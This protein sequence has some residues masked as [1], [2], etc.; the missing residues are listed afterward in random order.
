[1]NNDILS[2]LHKIFPEDIQKELSP[3]FEYYQN[4]KDDE[5]KMLYLYNYILRFQKIFNEGKRE[6][7]EKKNKIKIIPP[8]IF[9][10]QKKLII[11][12]YSISNREELNKPKIMISYEKTLKKNR[13][14]GDKKE[15]ESSEK[16]LINGDQSIPVN[17]NEKPKFEDFDENLILELNNSIDVKLP[18]INLSKYNINLSINKILELFNNSIIGTRVF[19]AYLLTINTEKE[20]DLKNSQNY[21]DTLYSIYSN[22]TKSVNNNS[23]IIPKLIQFMSSFEDMIAKLKNAGISF[24]S[25]QQLNNMKINSKN[26]F[27]TK[28]FKVSPNKQK[29]EWENEKIFKK[30]KYKNNYSDKIIDNS[31]IDAQIGPQVKGYN[32]RNINKDPNNNSDT[33]KINKSKAYESEEDGKNLIDI[34]KHHE[35]IEILDDIQLNDDFENKN[36]DKLLKFDYSEK[37]NKMNPSKLPRENFENLEKKF[38]EDYALKFIISGIKEIN[39]DDLALKY[40]GKEINEGYLD[41]ENNNI[42]F[43]SNLNKI[44]DSNKNKKEKD[45]KNN[46]YELSISKLIENSR[47]LAYKIYS[48]VAQLN[49]KETD[50]EILFNRL[51]ANI[52]LDT[53]RTISNENRF[54]NMLIICGL[55]TALSYLHIPYTLALIG[56]SGFKIRIKNADEPHNKL[57]LQKL[58]DCCFI[59][60]NVTQLA[61]CLKY[62]MD[63]YPAKDE[64]INRVYYIFTNGF[65]EELKKAKAWQTKIFNNKKNSFSFILT[66]SEVLDKE[67]NLEY[68]KILEQVWD[69]F[70]KEA[71]NSDSFVTLTKTCIKEINNLDKLVENLSKVLLR[72]TN[73]MNKNK[74]P[75]S[76]AKF[77][78]DKSKSEILSQDYINIFKQLLNDNY[79]IKEE[80]YELYIKKNKMPIIFDNQKDDKKDFKELCL[81]T[82]KIFQYNNLTPETQKRII[83]LAKLFKEKKEKIKTTSMNIIFKPNLPTQAI[84]VEEGTHLDITELIKYSIN[85]VPNP[86]L[87][88]EIRDGFIKN[89]S[90]SIVLDTSISCLNESCITHTF[91]TLRVLLNALSYDNIPC[92]DIVVTSD[93][94]PIV[95]SSE[96]SANEILNE[97]S[98]FW[99]ALLSCLEGESSSDLASAIKAAY[100]L[101]RARRKEYT[102]YIFVLTDG[103]YNVSERDRIIEVVNS[104]FSKNINLFGIGVGIYPKGIE[105]LFPQIIYSQNP[106]KLIDGISLFFGDIS[107][108]KN[109]EMKSFAKTIELEQIKDNCKKIEEDINNPKFKNLKKLLADIII[110]V[111]SFSFVNKELPIKDKDINPEGDNSSMYKQDIYKGQ[112]ILFAMFFSFDL[113]S[114]KGAK[115]EGNESKISPRY[116]KMSIGAEACISSVLK[117]YGY[118]VEVVTN[119]EAAI[120]E[121]CKKDKNNK[122]LYNSLWV[123]SGQEVPDLP[124][125]N[126]DPNAPYYVEQFVDCG[127]QFWKNGGSLVLMGENDPYNFQ[128]NLFLK[129]IV[130]PNGKKLSFKVGGN[131]DGTKILKPDYSGKLSKYPTF[132]KKKPEVNNYER[133]YL[134]HNLERIFEGITIGFVIDGNTE[135]F[136][137]FSKDSQG[138][139]NS[140]F[141]NGTDNK[142]SGEG[143][144][145]IDCGYTK[146][147]LNMKEKG[148]ERYLQNI[149][150][151]IGSAERRAGLGI[152]PGLYRPDG[153]DFKLDKS[154]EKFYK[155]NLKSFDVVYLVDA[156]SSMQEIIDKVKTYCEEISE[157]LKKEMMLYDFQFGGVFYRDPVDEKGDVHEFKELT[158]NIKEFKNFVSKIKAS[159]GGDDPEDWVGG[160]DYALNRMNWRDG[161]KLII[162]IADAG[163]HGLYYSSEDKYPEEGPKLDELIKKCGESK[164]NI[165][166]LEIYEETHDSFSR[167]K[168]IYKELFEKNVEITKFDENNKDPRYF[169]NLVIKAITKVT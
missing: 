47:F 145:F 61:T 162:H 128:I 127:I 103:L 70:D 160:Y 8:D 57:S 34:L 65:D 142:G 156:T 116:V 19:P 133:A 74:T 89:Y 55:T 22:L 5:E 1:M 4:S 10:E 152:E 6:L 72:E 159:G 21:F 98:H 63:K 167:I 79:F 18:D 113:K 68:K 83:L 163:A 67:T 96:K 85:K 150:G 80:F 73:P 29:N 107:S 62:F 82:G 7:S 50:N 169:T 14:E 38:K 75:K 39:K 36:D 52:L 109:I 31:K 164:I 66:E 94:Y 92:L 105:K 135:P 126:G 119:Y 41:D 86:K 122:C 40:E 51:E 118:Q 108:Y 33:S 143:D 99:A 37:I 139:I 35:K 43:L 11:D 90:V 45:S 165:S 93:K 144:I 15:I 137:P 24:E 27:I 20:E 77:N 106:S 120:N 117:Y 166:A 125:N 151:F 110:R 88:R 25:N 168:M 56:D 158:S 136:I 146:F 16:Y 13:K 53:S 101:I 157:V 124:S 115:I 138:G 28:P 112:K 161:H 26:S 84:L 104:C 102:N 87:Y 3:D 97:K 76:K 134:A 2:E 59:K 95:L 32:K 9:D 17:I 71:Q 30:F 130:L 69:E 129:K 12:F 154:P 100:N 153:L 49:Y 42:N 155:Y 123:V 140:M 132:N 121:L 111:E 149:G 58:Y 60:R 81:N 78:I 44:D 54:Y 48:A 148:T 147:F 141:Y 114:Q 23:L 46:K 64:S 131:H 91:Q